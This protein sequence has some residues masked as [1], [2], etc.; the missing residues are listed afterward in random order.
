MENISSRQTELYKF[1][2]N[3]EECLVNQALSGL[4]ITLKL[5]DQGK[6]LILTSDE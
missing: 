3:I 5:A 4:G 2:K 1:T 6:S